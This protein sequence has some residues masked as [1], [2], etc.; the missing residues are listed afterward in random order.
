MGLLLGI[1]TAGPLVGVALVYGDVL[2]GS[3]SARVTRGAEARLTPA[4]AELLQGR[5]PGA[6]AVAVGPGAFTG[7]RVGVATALGLATALGVSVVPVPSLMARA[8]SAAGEA[9][10]LALLDARKERFYGGIFDTR[11]PVPVALGAERDLPLEELL[12]V[13]PALVVG[14]GAQVAR[15]ACLAA[16]HRV[17]PAPDRGPALGVACLGQILWARG[18]VVAP[19]VLQIRYL[20]PPDAIPP[21]GLPQCGISTE[22]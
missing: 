19:E 16:G 3:W 22:G 1:D 11:G 14:E 7:L 20:R 6:I 4:I 15:E 10:V 17:P 5:R 21:A 12:A 2:E 13:A 9:R 18:Q 8:A